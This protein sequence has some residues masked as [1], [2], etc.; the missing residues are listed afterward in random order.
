MGSKEGIGTV[1]PDRGNAGLFEWCNS[2]IVYKTTEL[3][4]RIYDVVK[5]YFSA[6]AAG[7]H[8]Y[9]T[10]SS[11]YHQYLQDERV[12]YKKYFYALRPLLACQFIQEHKCPPPVLFDELM[13][14]N[15]SE[16]LRDGIKKLLEIKI[17]TDEKEMSMPIPVIQNYII[18]EINRQKLYLSGAED[19]R[20]PSWDKLNECFFEVLEAE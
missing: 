16:E 2:P 19:D 12:K 1:S 5:D 10:V 11:T 6:K 15:M 9:G 17:K 4:G 8:Y 7:Y 20:I 14:M 18:E 13:K 3:W